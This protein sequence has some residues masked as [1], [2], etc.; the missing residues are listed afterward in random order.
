MEFQSYKP[1]KLLQIYVHHQNV[2]FNSKAHN[3]CSLFPDDMKYFE[4]L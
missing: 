1:L 2:T 4:I 3:K